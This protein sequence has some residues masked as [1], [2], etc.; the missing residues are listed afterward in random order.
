MRSGAGFYVADGMR[1]H[2]MRLVREGGARGGA[3]DV[4]C[5]P[6]VRPGEF[7]APASPAGGGGD[8]RA[9]REGGAGGR[10]KGVPA[11]P[12]CGAGAHAR[13]IAGRGGMAPAFTG[14]VRGGSMGHVP[15][16]AVYAAAWLAA[17]AVVASVAACVVSFG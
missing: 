17:G 9:V 13:R 16:I 5:V 10:E 11:V 8:V 4:Q 3:E 15:G 1:F 14:P 12:R 6:C 7:R 2:G